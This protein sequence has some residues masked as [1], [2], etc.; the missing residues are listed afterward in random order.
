MGETCER[1]EGKREK[2]WRM[3]IWKKLF[4]LGD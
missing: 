3:V 2:E 4:S 1:D